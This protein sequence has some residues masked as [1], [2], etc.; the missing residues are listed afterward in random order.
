MTT[1]NTPPET[2][3]TDPIPPEAPPEAP[4]TEPGQPT[5]DDPDA[6]FR[7]HEK[8]RHENI[9]LRKR[10]ST[11]EAELEKT[12]KAGLSEA[13]KAIDEA[14]QRGVTEERAKLGVQLLQE[15][16]ITRATGK[17]VDPTDAVSLLDV[18]SF[19]LDKPEEI[20]TAIADLIKAKPHLGVANG[21][22][23]IDQGPQGRPISP[24]E[25]GGD[26]LR[27]VARNA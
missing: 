24:D 27:Q 25:T 2:P 19:D 11:A 15:R 18:S 10:A 26:W 12:R 23:G 13:E 21:G 4:P 20:D 17:L 9:A 16:I 22:R 8:Y 7:S 5:V 6:L 14:Y 3:P 1:E